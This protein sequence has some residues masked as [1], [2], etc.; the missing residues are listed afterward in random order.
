MFKHL[1]AGGK[2]NFQNAK[3]NKLR[4]MVK[5]IIVPDLVTLSNL[6]GARD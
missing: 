4:V 3:A 1:A 2:V 6:E 5:E